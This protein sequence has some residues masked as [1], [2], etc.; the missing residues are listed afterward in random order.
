MTATFIGVDVSKAKLDVGVLPT[1]ERFTLLNDEAGIAELVRRCSALTPTRIVLEATGGY[2]AAAA[3]A[4][5]QASLPAC[6]VNPRMVRD[7]ARAAGRLAKTD[8]IDAEVL[9]LFGERLRPEVRPLQDDTVRELSSLLQRRRQLVEMRTAEKNRLEKNPTRSVAKEIANHVAW[10]DK[11]IHKV[12]DDI[13]RTIRNS[14]LYEDKRARLT[15][16]PGV[17]DVVA[18]TLLAELPEL[19]TLDRKRIASLAGLA[20]FNNDSGSRSSGSPQ[21]PPPGS[22]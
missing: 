16:V 10:L 12:D 5:R 18:S 20:P 1:G 17:G 11:R 3:L 22:S 4:L 2:E 13:D 15:S 14:P 6:V 8:A 21:P 19:G 9:A 7:F